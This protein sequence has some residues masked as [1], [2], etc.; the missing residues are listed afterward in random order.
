MEDAG[1]AWEQGGIVVLD[2][3]TLDD[4]AGVGELVAILVYSRPREGLPFTDDRAVLEHP[5]HHAVRPALGLLLV[6]TALVAQRRKSHCGQ[7]LRDRAAA[8]IILIR[9]IENLPNDGRNGLVDRIHILAPTDHD[10]LRHRKE[11]AGA[12]VADIPARPTFL[13]RMCPNASTNL[14]QFDRVRFALHVGEIGGVLMRD[15]H[16]DEIFHQHEHAR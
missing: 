2:D 1:I 15:H 8:N 16:V 7:S 9:P 10:W 5:Q 3:G 6:P 14:A 12:A 4:L 11:P 13:H